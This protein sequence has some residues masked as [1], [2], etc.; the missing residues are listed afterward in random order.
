MAVGFHAESPVR[1][2]YSQSFSLD[3]PGIE[4]KPGENGALLFVYVCLC[5]GVFQVEMALKKKTKEETV[6]NCLLVDS[7]IWANV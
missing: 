5:A 3:K 7:K 6:N 4:S 1:P 2:S